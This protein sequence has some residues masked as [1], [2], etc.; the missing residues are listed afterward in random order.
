MQ[1][2]K[3]LED[4]E[5]GICDAIATF[6][7]PRSAVSRSATL[8]E[9]DVDS[10]DLVE[11]AQVVEEDYGIRLETGDFKDVV[12]VGDAIDVVASRAAT[13]QAS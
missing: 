11:L 5:S 8:E 12:T 7:P 13:S 2:I 6:G 1:E 10:L 4:I 9:L 3:T